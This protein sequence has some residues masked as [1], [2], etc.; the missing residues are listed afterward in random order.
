MP[1]ITQGK[2]NW[3]FL[4][5]IIILAVIVGGG[6][7]WYAKKQ[8][9]YYQPLGMEKQER[10]TIQG[11]LLSWVSGKPLK[12]LKFIIMGTEITTDDNGKFIFKKEKASINT[13]DITAVGYIKKEVPISKSEDTIDIGQVVLAPEGKTYWVESSDAENNK[14]KVSIWESNYDGSEKRIVK[15]LPNIIAK[16]GKIIMT[17]SPYFEKIAIL[18]I[19]PIETYLANCRLVVIDFKNLDKIQTFQVSYEVNMHTVAAMYTGRSAFQ[20]PLQW[21]INGSAILW[22][23]DVKSR[24]VSPQLNGFILFYVDVG[25]EVGKQELI[26]IPSPLAEYTGLEGGG[27]MF[28]GSNMFKISPSGSFV[29]FEERFLGEGSKLQQGLMTYNAKERKTK[30]ITITDYDEPQTL[31]LVENEVFFDNQDNL[32]FAL[33]AE[34]NS[35]IPNIWKKYNLNTNKVEKFNQKPFYWDFIRDA[36]FNSNGK[37][38][39]LCRTNAESLC[40]SDD[41]GSTQNTLLNYYDTGVSHYG[42]KRLFFSKDNNYLIFEDFELHSDLNSTQWVI[43]LNSGGVQKIPR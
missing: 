7:L 42:F 40:I 6:A 20:T 13:I 43:D 4:L 31:S 30:T 32:Y 27:V 14:K 35:L 16:N 12:N 25:K 41:L 22:S 5:I 10:I 34:T 3:K 33:S 28:G 8:E 38:I 9:K 39:S 29:V 11:Q 2:T 1:F 18:L 23:A 21:S 17:L 19:E 36:V 37:A 26:E 15:E 24:Y